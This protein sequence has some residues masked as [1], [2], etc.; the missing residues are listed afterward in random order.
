MEMSQGNPLYS[1]LKQTK[2]PFFFFS[3]NREQKG[4]TGPVW[5]L[6]P[7][8]RGEDIGKGE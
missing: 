8:G 4:K 3:K 1:Y 5:E 6:V 7:V 2:M